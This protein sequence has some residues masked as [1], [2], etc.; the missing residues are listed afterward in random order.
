MSAVMIFGRA[1]RLLG[2]LS[3]VIPFTSTTL[4]PNLRFF[5]S[6]I[7]YDFCFPLYMATLLQL[8][9]LNDVQNDR[10]IHNTHIPRPFAYPSAPITAGTTD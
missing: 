7:I 9:V 4:S 2:V 10:V 5:S 3:Q 1:S 8:V 6:Y